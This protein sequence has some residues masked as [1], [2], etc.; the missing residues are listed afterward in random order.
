MSESSFS[1]SRPERTSTMVHQKVI[2]LWRSPVSHLLAWCALCSA[3]LFVSSC[4]TPGASTSKNAVTAPVMQAESLRTEQVHLAPVP[5]ITTDVRIAS[6]HLYL[7]SRSNVGLMQPAVDAQGNVWVGEMNANQLDRLNT[8]SGE[9]TRW[10]PPGAQYGI[11]N[12]VLDGQGNVWFAEQNA[13]YIGRFDPGQHAFHLFP[14]G[15][16]KGSPLGPQD[17]HIDSQGLLWFAGASGGAIGQLD[18]KTGE[19]RI[20][21]LPSSPSSIA[22]TPDGHVWFGVD[23]A[24]D[25]LDPSTGQITSYALPDPQTQVFSME[26]DTEGR[27]WFTEVLPGKLGMFDQETDSLTELPLPAVS[28]NAPALYELVLDHQGM[29]WFVDVDANA[30]VRYAPGKQTLT[31]YRLSMPGS[32]PFG[33]TLDPAGRVWFTVGGAPTNYVGEMSR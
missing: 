27:L 1:G 32:A 2:S 20:W 25:V 12:T 6:K 14:L 29:V 15:S 3:F 8:Q 13:N 30:L 22:T 19:V 31:F 28:G 5:A 9:V 16:S 21:P 24:L 11:M 23:G 18:P 10:T 17:L 4:R 26:A 33:L 7:V